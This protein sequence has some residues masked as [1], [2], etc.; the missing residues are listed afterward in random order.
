MHSSTGSTQ[1]RIYRHSTGQKLR[2][3]PVQFSGDSHIQHFHVVGERLPDA[4][5]LTVPLMIA[6]KEYRYS[7]KPDFDRVVSKRPLMFWLDG[8]LD[9]SVSDILPLQICQIEGELN[10]QHMAHSWMGVIATICRRELR[11]PVV[12]EE[13]ESVCQQVVEALPQVQAHVQTCADWVKKILG[14]NPLHEYSIQSISL[15]RKRGY[16]LAHAYIQLPAFQA[17][18]E[19][20]VTFALTQMLGTDEP[21]ISLFYD[22]R[23]PDQ[24]VCEIANSLAYR[25]AGDTPEARYEELMDVLNEIGV[26]NAVAEEFREEGAA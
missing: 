22:A 16:T 11:D 15:E 24:V 13:Y 8:S 1:Q 3:R 4:P 25:L 17:S 20:V 9:D 18:E 12:A 2:I 7:L 19:A 23:R 14:V 21:I 10:I 5:T 26:P 6:G